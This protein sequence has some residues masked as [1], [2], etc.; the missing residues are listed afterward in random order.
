MFG[1]S[2]NSLKKIPVDLNNKELCIYG[3][4]LILM[5]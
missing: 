5:F 4:L 1:F 3:F 2:I